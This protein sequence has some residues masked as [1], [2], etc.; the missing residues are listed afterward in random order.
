MSS[1]MIKA[2][3]CKLC[4]PSRCRMTLYMESCV[5]WNNLLG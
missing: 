3:D 4:P 1:G 5:V 2:G